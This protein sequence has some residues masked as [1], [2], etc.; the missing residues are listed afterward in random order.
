MRSG[1]V[2]ELGLKRRSTVGYQCAQNTAV[3]S[4]LYSYLQ[5]CVNWG[6]FE[7]LVICAPKNLRTEKCF[8]IAM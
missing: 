6:Y 2:H 8:I 7:S 4:I 5:T 1:W 3:L